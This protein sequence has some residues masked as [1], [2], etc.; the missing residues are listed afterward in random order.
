MIDCRG[1]NGWFVLNEV[2]TLV[3]KT[4]SYVDLY[5][6]IHG[7]TAPIVF[8]GHKDELLELFENIVRMI[9]RGGLQQCPKS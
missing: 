6:R 1:R 3:G 4:D 9:K 5:S 2:K 7:Q 8:I